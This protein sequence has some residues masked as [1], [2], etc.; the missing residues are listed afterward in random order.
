MNVAHILDKSTP[1]KIS[2]VA[3]P[4]SDNK[5]AE[6]WNKNYRNLLE[7]LILYVNHSPSEESTIEAV[8]AIVRDKKDLG[9]FITNILTHN[10]EENL[11]FQA[12]FAHFLKQGD[13]E[14]TAIRSG[15]LKALWGV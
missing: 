2:M 15:V 8:K 6:N 14:Q 7:G 11:P 4:K 13:N 10:T 5:E 3:I 9:S 1:E 12:H